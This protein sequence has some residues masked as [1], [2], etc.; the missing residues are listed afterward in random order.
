MDT[1]ALGKGV[2]LLQARSLWIRSEQIKT[3]ESWSL[4]GNQT[5][6]ILMAVTQLC[7]SSKDSLRL[8]LSW[9]WC[10]HSCSPAWGSSSRAVQLPPPASCLHVLSSSASLLPPL[11]QLSFPTPST[12]RNSV[13]RSLWWLKDTQPITLGVCLFPPHP[14]LGW[15]FYDWRS[16]LVALPPVNSLNTFTMSDIRIRW[17]KNPGHKISMFYTHTQVKIHTYV[18]IHRAVH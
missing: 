4:K 12:G 13:G 18:K 17:G 9:P 6:F 10:S 8:R 15:Y 5:K 11:S 14:P 7:I 16:L 1:V 2:S 3:T